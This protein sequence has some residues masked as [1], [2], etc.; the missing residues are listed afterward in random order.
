[1]VIPIF[2]TNDISVLKCVH[3]G[4]VLAVGGCLWAAEA[5]FDTHICV[6]AMKSTNPPCNCVGIHSFPA[7][8][9]HQ[10]SA[11]DKVVLLLHW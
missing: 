10:E 1:M 2:T 8:N 6:T 4:D 11:G 9:I 7:I 5:S 3:F